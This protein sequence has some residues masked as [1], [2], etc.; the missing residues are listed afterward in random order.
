KALDEAFPGTRH[1]RCWC[2]KVSNVLDNAL[3]NCRDFV[4]G[5]VAVGMVPTSYIVT[6]FVACLVDRH[7][8]I[9]FLL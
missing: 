6:F 2:H 1:Q 9:R 5:W 3:F 7:V 8:Y 4:A